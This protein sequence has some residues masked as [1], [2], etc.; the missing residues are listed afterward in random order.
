MS[1]GAL[2]QFPNTQTGFKDLRQWVGAVLPTRVVFEATGPYHGTLERALGPHLPLVKVKPLQARRFAQA[3]ETRAKTDQV[4]AK[5]LAHM[6]K[7][8]NFWNL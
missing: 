8:L 5:M 7:P 3:R 1:D 4:D 2:G 6:G